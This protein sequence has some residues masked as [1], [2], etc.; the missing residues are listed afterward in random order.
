MMSMM[1]SHHSS[2]VSFFFMSAFAPF[3]LKVHNGVAGKFL[4]LAG[5]GKEAIHIMSVR[6]RERVFDAPNLLKHQVTGRFLPS[7]IS[8]FAH[9]RCLEQTSTR[10]LD[11]GERLNYGF[12]AL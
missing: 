11:I 7:N 8:R 9:D 1:S 4:A 3:G 10:L 5:F 12:R 2:D 6:G